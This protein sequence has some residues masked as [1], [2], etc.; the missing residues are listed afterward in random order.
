[1]DKVVKIYCGDTNFYGFVEPRNFVPNKKEITHLYVWWSC[2]IHEFKNLR[3]DDF[4]LKPRK[5]GPTNKSTFTV[6]VLPTHL[7]GFN[8]K[9]DKGVL[10]YRCPINLTLL[11]V[12]YYASNEVF[13][14]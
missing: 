3:T 7:L 11:C 10:G 8:N 6:H 9:L 12:T 5:L 13:D 1:M 14:V 2:Q 4:S